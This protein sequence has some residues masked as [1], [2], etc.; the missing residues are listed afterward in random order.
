MDQYQKAHII[1]RVQTF[2]SAHST[3]LTNSGLTAW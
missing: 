1:A 2:E 3:K